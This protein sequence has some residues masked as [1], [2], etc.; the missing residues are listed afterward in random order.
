MPSLIQAQ[1]RLIA[2]VNY[3]H[4]GHRAR[5]QRSAVKELRR[6]LARIGVPAAQH[7]AVVRDAVDMAELEAAATE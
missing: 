4:P 3:C 7:L 6:Y 1:E 2:R 5:V